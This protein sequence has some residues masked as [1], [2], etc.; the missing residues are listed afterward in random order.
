MLMRIVSLVPKVTPL[1]VFQSSPDQPPDFSLLNLP[2]DLWIALVIAASVL[3][4]FLSFCGLVVW[5]LRRNRHLLHLE[6]IK[7]IES[8]QAPAFYPPDRSK[9]RYGHNAFW[10]AFWIGAIL[11]MGIASAAASATSRGQFEHIAIVITIWA[12]VVP[13]CVAGVVCATV[14]MVSARRVAASESIKTVLAHKPAQG[15]GG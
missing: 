5:H 14:L 15:Q 11:P 8:G 12:C 6:R 7:A 13:I 9:E 3:I 4:A 10:I 1:F 2:L